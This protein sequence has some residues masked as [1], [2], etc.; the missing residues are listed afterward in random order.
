MTLWIRNVVITFAN[1]VVLRP[2]FVGSAVPRKGVQAKNFAGFSLAP[3]G[4]SSDAGSV[5]MS[6]ARV[7]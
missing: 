7:R 5:L 1:W 3:G 6:L 4:L 2:F